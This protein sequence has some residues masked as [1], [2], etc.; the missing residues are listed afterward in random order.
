MYG[1]SEEGKFLFSKYEADK[2]TTTSEAYARINHLLD[3]TK[4]AADDIFNYVHTNQLPGSKSFMEVFPNAKKGREELDNIV[5]R[6]GI[7]NPENTF[8]K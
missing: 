3:T 1:T 7:E 2:M 5:E 6:L 8:K 4:E